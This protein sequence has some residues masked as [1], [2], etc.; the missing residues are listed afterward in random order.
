[1]I[2]WIVK[3]M[4]IFFVI[5]YFKASNLNFIMNFVLLSK[6][7]KENLQIYYHPTSLHNALFCTS[8]Y[9]IMQCRETKKVY[10]RTTMKEDEGA[11]MVYLL[12]S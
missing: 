2:L 3:S 6:T 10:K 1:M 12:I 5:N 7:Y 4:M 9:A 11:L 8:S